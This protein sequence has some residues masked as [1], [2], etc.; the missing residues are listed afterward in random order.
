MFSLN[1]SMN[2]ST[3][4]SIA[5]DQICLRSCL[6]IPSLLP[7][8]FEDAMKG[9]EFSWEICSIFITNLM[10]LE[11]YATTSYTLLFIHKKVLLLC[12]YYL[13]NFKNLSIKAYYCF[14]LL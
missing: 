3:E 8:G 9:V 5:K 14:L 12:S 11:K 10:Q 7:I 6:E 4:N 1:I 2:F 13:N